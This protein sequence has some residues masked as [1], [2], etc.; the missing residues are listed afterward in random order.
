MSPNHEDIQK[1]TLLFVG[2]LKLRPEQVLANIN[3]LLEGD[4]FRLKIERPETLFGFEREPDCYAP[5]LEEAN[6]TGS[7]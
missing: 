2:Q 7:D 1:A 5:V 3:A 6:A 4:G